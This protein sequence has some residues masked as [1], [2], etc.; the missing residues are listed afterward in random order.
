MHLEGYKFNYQQM[1]FVPVSVQFELVKVD[2]YGFRR[3]I[4]SMAE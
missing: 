2:N 1:D 3:N 4:L